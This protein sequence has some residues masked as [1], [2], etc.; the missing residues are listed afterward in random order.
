MKMSSYEVSCFMDAFVEDYG[1]ECGDAWG[2]DV[3]CILNKLQFGAISE[4]EAIENLKEYYC[5]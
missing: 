5:I 3:E 2:Y 4:A 1:V